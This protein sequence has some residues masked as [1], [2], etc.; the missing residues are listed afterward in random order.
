MG[1][2]K[3]KIGRNDVTQRLAELAYGK[4]NDCVKL[5][6]EE[7]PELENLD[8]SLLSEVKRNEKG[9]VEIRL[10]DRLKVLEQ[11]AR[12]TQGDG[13]EMEGLLNAIRG[14]EEG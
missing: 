12:M 7:A 14:S 8:L 3:K 6:L 10:L 11:L 9:A 13:Q 5:V 4:V 2:P 1:R